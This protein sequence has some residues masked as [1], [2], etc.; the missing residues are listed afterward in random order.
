MDIHFLGQKLNDTEMLVLLP[1]YIHRISRAGDSR[2][3]STVLTGVREPQI[4]FAGEEEPLLELQVPTCSYRMGVLD[5]GYGFIR[6]EY[7]PKDEKHIVSD[8]TAGLSFVFQE[9]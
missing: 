6:L 4:T 3:N 9:S 1:A 2:T 7:F 8:D 5:V